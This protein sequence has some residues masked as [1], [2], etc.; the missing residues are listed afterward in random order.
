MSVAQRNTP[1]TPPGTTEVGIAATK[2]LGAR[3]GR[4]QAVV[5]NTDS[6]ATLY[7]GYSNDITTANAPISLAPD[8]SWIED[9]STTAIFGVVASGTLVA[10]HQEIE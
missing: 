10:A 7:L 3:S 6:T 9:V 8:E 1:V 2:I 5:R 4:T